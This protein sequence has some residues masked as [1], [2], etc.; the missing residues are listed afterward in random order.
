MPRDKQFSLSRA[1]RYN[2]RDRNAGKIIIYTEGDIT[3]PEYIKDWIKDFA[4]KNSLNPN[5][6]KTW[7]EIIPSHD[8][9]EP[10][11]IVENLI[12]DKSP[13]TNELDNFYVIFDEDDRSS[14]GKD[15][16]NFQN[17]F[18]TA[19]DNNVYVICSNRSV[20]LWAVL[21]FSDTTPMTQKELETEL[22]KF[23]PKYHSGKNKR[24]DFAVMQNKGNENKAIK[25]AQTLRKNNKKASGDWRVRPSTNFDELIEAMKEFI[26]KR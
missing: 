20:E 14:K 26:L 11:K 24:F 2:R 8:E 3:E 13:K 9:S 12:K 19:G 6:V 21:H 23:M 1:D 25:R 18:K 16:K 22:K 5:R 4:V 15:K 17:A 10:L 7:F